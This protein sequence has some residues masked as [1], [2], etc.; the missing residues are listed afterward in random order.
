M[1]RALYAL[2]VI[3]ILAA[4]VV[5]GFA[6]VCAKVIEAAWQALRM[7]AENWQLMMDAARAERDGEQPE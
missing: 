1:R 3:A 2:K 7:A 6:L 4:A 5:L